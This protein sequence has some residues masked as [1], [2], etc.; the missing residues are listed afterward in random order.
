MIG[1]SSQGKIEY[2]DNNA[3]NKISPNF[4]TNKIRHLKYL[5]YKNDYVASASYDYTVII[6]DTQTWTSI[7]RY[8]NFMLLV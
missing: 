3:F 4:H 1:D 8:T 2:F 6:W 7:Q 5:P